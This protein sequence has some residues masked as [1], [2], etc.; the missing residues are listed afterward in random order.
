[1]PGKSVPYSTSHLY[2]SNRPSEYVDLQFPAE[3]CRHASLQGF[4]DRARH[5]HII[6]ELLRAVVHRNPLPFAQVFIVGGF[7]QVL[8][9]PPTAYA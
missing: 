2:A 3:L 1:M 4:H 5:A 6:S 8:K 7:V 9:A